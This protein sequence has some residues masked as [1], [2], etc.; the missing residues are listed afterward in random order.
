[1]ETAVRMRAIILGFSATCPCR[2]RRHG[3]HVRERAGEVKQ[4]EAT[5][6]DAGVARGRLRMQ[7]LMNPMLQRVGK[8]KDEELSKA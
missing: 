2:F 7:R 5:T 1:M 3:A 6:E 4:E 8:S